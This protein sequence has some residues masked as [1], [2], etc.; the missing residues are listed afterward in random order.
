MQVLKFGGSSVANADNINRVIELV[1]QA[2]AN[3][4]TILV[5]SALGGITD[6]LIQAGQ[7]AASGDESYKEK[8]Q[9]IERR[10][11]D[12]VKALLPITRQSSALSLVKTRCNEIED[13]CSGIFLLG[14]LSARTQDKIVSYGE[15]LSSLIIDARLTSLEVPHQWKDSRD[16]I[17][18]DSRFGHAASG[19]CHHEP[20]DLRIHERRS[21]YPAVRPSRLRRLRRKR[22]HHH[23]R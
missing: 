13:I 17:R 10:H 20:P 1:K 19:L 7:A 21:D 6:M 8:V 4:R 15:L 22:H 18:T 23:P 12:T 9:D 5:V 3:D 14:E 2:T 11:L 16:L